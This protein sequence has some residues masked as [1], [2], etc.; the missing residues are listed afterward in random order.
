MNRT[1]WRRRLTSRRTRVVAGV[2][3]F[4]VAA[5][6]IVTA[7]PWLSTTYDL[8]G[9]GVWLTNGDRIGRLNTQIP[10]IDYARE[11]V[12][13]TLL[14]DDAGALIV[15]PGPTTSVQRLDAADPA[16]EPDLVLVDGEAT[17]AAAGGRVA[18]LADGA[19]R[20]IGRDGHLEVEDPPVAR[21][22]PDGVLAVGPGGEVAAYDPES[23]TAHVLRPDDTAARTVDVGPAR[24][25]DRDL[26]LTLLGDEP[27]V[28][29]GTRL[30]R[31]GHDPVDLGDGAVVQHP[32]PDAARTIVATPGA[33]L[34]VAA[35]GDAAVLDDGGTGA[36]VRPVVTDDCTYA[37]WRGDAGPGRMVVRCDDDDPLETD[38]A[39]GGQ[40]AFRVGGPAVVLNQ[41][42]DGTA[43]LVVDG[44]LRRVTTWPEDEERRSESE[45]IEETE[46]DPDQQPPVA[47]DDTG[48]DRLG[49]RPGRV[50]EVPVV[51]NDYDANADPLFVADLDTDDDRLR[52]AEDGRSLVIDLTDTGEDDADLVRAR[53]RASDGIA[54]SDWAAVEVE[55]VVG[56]GRPP[57][58]NPG[59]TL[60]ADVAGGQEI[61]YDVIPSIWDPDGDPTY[62]AAVG[63][64]A[65]GHVVDVDADGR[66]RF[67]ASGRTGTVSVPVT[68]ADTFGQE[69][70]L[71]VVVTVAAPGSGDLGPELRND[72]LLAA[73]GRPARLEPLANDHDP[74]GLGLR[75]AGP[76]EA[77]AG[78]D[79]GGLG[80]LERTDDRVTFTPERPGDYLLT[81][82]V[83]GGGDERGT[84]LVRVV[85]PERR[86]PVARP[87]VVVVES[88]A[89]ADVDAIHDDYDPD[90]SLVSITDVEHLETRGLDDV[91]PDGPPTALAF[92]VD[93][94][95]RTFV[96][97]ASPAAEPGLIVEVAY[98]VSDGALTARS[99]VTIVVVAPS[100]NRPPRPVLPAPSVAVRA[101]DVTTVPLAALARDPDG[102]PL[103]VSVPEQPAIGEAAANGDSV[104]YFPPADA[105]PGTTVT[106][107]V[108]VSDPAGDSQ[109]LSFTVRVGDPGG[110]EAPVAVDLEARVR[111]GGRVVIPVPLDGADPDG[112]WVRLRGRAG[113][114]GIRGNVIE[115]HEEQALVYQAVDPTFRGEETFQYTIVDGTG[116]E[117]RPAT[118]RVQVTASTGGH[119]PVAVTDEVVG[120]PGRSVA[121]DPTAND[122]DL[123]GDPL[124]LVG[125][126]VTVAA[127]QCR[128]T[129]EEDRVVT[130]LAADATE[131]CTILYEVVDVDDGGGARSQPVGGRIA[132]AVSE[133][134]AGRRPIARIDYP[135]LTGRDT[136]LEVD[137]VANDFDPDGTAD[138]LTVELVD[139]GRGARLDR[140]TGRVTVEVQD[141]P[142]MVRYRVTDEDG[143]TGDALVRVPGAVDN[144]PPRLRPDA[145]PLSVA[146]DQQLVVDLDDHIEDPDGDA[147]AYLSASSAGADSA[148]LASRLSAGRLVFRASSRDRVG[149]VTVHVTAVD[150]APNPLAQVITLVVDVESPANR[151]PQWTGSL[152][153][154]SVEQ[155]GGGDAIELRSYASD[156]DLDD[157]A[158][159]TFGGS[160][161]RRGVTLTVGRAGRLAVAAAN[162]A[163][164]GDVVSF[165]LTVTDPDGA[166][167]ETTCAVEVTASQA[168]PLVAG[169]SEVSA[170]QGEAVVVDVT[171]LVANAVGRLEV[172]DA[173]LDAGPGFVV[174]DGTTFTYTS[175]ADHVGDVTV[176]YFVVDAL[177]QPGNPRRTSGV[178]TVRVAGRPDAPTGVVATATG[179]ATIRIEWTNGSFNGSPPEGFVVEAVGGGVRRTCPASPC[180]L[181]AGDGVRNDTSYRFTV[182]A[183][184]A[185]GASAPSVPSNEVRADAPPDAPTALVATV[186]PSGAETTGQVRF[187]WNASTT[188]GSPVTRYELSTGQTTAGTTTEAVVS[189]PNGVEICASV[190]AHNQADAPSPPS[191]TA[192]ATPYGRPSVTGLSVSATDGDDRA[193][194]RWTESGNGRP[195]TARSVTGDCT[196]EE[197]TAGQATVVCGG[198]GAKTITVTIDNAAGLRSDP[199][200][201]TVD[202]YEIPQVL[203]AS[204][205]AAYES[206]VVEASVDD[207]G[208]AV[209]RWVFAL[210]TGTEERATGGPHEVAAPPGQPVTLLTVTACRGTVCSLPYPVGATVVPWTDPPEPTD[211]TITRELDDE[212]NPTGQATITFQWARPAGAGGT[213]F[214]VVVTPAP[215][216][217]LPV[218]VDGTNTII[219]PAG[220]DAGTWTIQIRDVTHDLSGPSV[221]VSLDPFEPGGG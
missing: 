83:D 52:V 45:V 191:A 18:A 54:V 81:Y 158:K 29:D 84:I 96:A 85:D 62:L 21:L 66:L 208:A 115:D 188:S 212:G 121:V 211:A 48:D 220:T 200:R 9:S 2:A 16:S 57:R 201:T 7:R 103:L 167:D 138:A 146:A 130:S 189:G 149:P 27:V 157:D 111:L 125:A 209:D 136:R 22:G 172:V 51:H 110:D 64:P 187:T 133:G 100:P 11:G 160:A 55:V 33:L 174:V 113:T 196:T 197:V 1:A 134:F 164:V 12:T 17:V 135:Q 178:V 106:V 139:P 77:K 163:R 72:F 116:R 221:E 194:V 155:G 37:A 162:E 180:T 73:T 216:G 159:L 150:D 61:A 95:F 184:N 34:A 36:A 202:F 92:G 43:H 148:L 156:L 166:S 198:R 58:A 44:Q 204:I 67:R 89:T 218:A 59:V 137:V 93:D 129:V 102:D 181:D 19:L 69:A 126:S 112:D 5:T 152:R 123:D 119:A 78:S 192:C 185:I 153:C 86:P 47:V 186:I 74:T 177:D 207:G 171:G 13:G 39:S 42:Q 50:T 143:L 203:S 23:G 165:P 128:A 205:A 6:V 70:D 117:S 217:P 91:D 107:P 219:V 94:D 179:S 40:W 87:D 32:G 24:T 145:P 108:E 4:A 88:G 118:V 20:I 79:V 195:A 56:D 210:S 183:T 82:A 132:V 114:A 76:L 8:H 214:R 168:P 193:V 190:V 97:D 46:P 124:Q 144:R 14:Q 169:S 35:S 170:R 105:A 99:S 30:L 206:V 213:D 3:T 104:R 175:P 10:E 131:G 127:G 90:G 25:R 71:S 31:A 53:Y 199:A 122:L 41:T 49:A 147:V 63:T 75:L 109:S 80:R 161:T 215:G 141:E 182:T 101:G 151:P 60:R 28:L 26:R 154:P 65:G 15:V 98:V 142:R 176:R 68:V 140:D 38:L 120:R 173:R